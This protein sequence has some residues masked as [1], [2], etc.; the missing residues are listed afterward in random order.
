MSLGI[1]HDANW[2]ISCTSIYTYRLLNVKIQ[3]LL[4]QLP[5]KE[6]QRTFTFLFGTSEPGGTSVPHLIVSDC[7]ELRVTAKL[8]PGLQRA[9]CAQATAFPLGLQ[10]RNIVA[11][12][13]FFLLNLVV[14][15]SICFCTI[16][17]KKL[18]TASEFSGCLD[19]LV[20][21]VL[22]GSV[23]SWQ[24]I[25]CNTWRNLSAFFLNEN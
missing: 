18:P 5:F 2:A 10:C 15:L 13:F 7:T 4:C 12:F 17:F 22:C 21:A 24:I 19:S 8:L 9:G 23:C 20:V 16:F 6:T 1:L 14:L 25:D 11:F 3:T